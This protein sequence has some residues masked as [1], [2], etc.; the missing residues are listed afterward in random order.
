MSV[1]NFI[2]TFNPFLFEPIAGLK[3]ARAISFVPVLGIVLWARWRRF[4]PWV[5][6]EWASTL[7]LA[8]SPVID[9]WYLIWGLPVW[10]LRGRW[11]G[12]CA[13]TVI[14]FS[15]LFYV[16][17]TDPATIRRCA[18]LAVSIV[19]LCEIVYDRMRHGR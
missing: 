8:F 4:D 6:W 14:P 17:G 2:L 1:E 13:A 12:L 19:G 9:P 11:Y 5:T 15:Y 3:G 10:V 18:W 16:D 7:W